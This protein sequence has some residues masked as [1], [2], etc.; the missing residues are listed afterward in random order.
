MDT[1]FVAKTIEV[2]GLVVKIVIVYEV[3]VQVA[4]VARVD[5]RLDWIDGVT[6]VADKVDI[7]R[8]IGFS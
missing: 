6:K 2:E 4:G 5:D 3:D 1:R 8:V 7:H